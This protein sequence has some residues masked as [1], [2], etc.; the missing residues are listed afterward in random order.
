MY[1]LGLLVVTAVAFAACAA[2]AVS[3]AVKEQDKVDCGGLRVGKE[4]CASAQTIKCSVGAT[5]AELPCSHQLVL[6]QVRPTPTH[7]LVC[8]LCGHPAS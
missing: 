3:C 8:R 7:M 4:L 1:M 6:Q 5:T 2:A